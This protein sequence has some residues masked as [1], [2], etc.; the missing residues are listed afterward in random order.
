MAL[1]QPTSV[2]GIG[3]ESLKVLYPRPRKQGRTLRGLSRGTRGVT[4][5]CF[6]MLL[7]DAAVTTIRRSFDLEDNNTIKARDTAL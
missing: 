3:M 1:A 2:I 4:Q 7:I 6:A 5:V